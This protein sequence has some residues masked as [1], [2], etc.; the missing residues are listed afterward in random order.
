MTRLICTP[1]SVRLLGSIIVDG[2]CSHY[3]ISFYKTQLQLLQTQTRL[4]L[5]FLSS[6]L[7]S[8]KIA[9]V[10]VCIY[11]FF[12]RKYLDSKVTSNFCMSASSGKIHTKLSVTTAFEAWFHWAPFVF[13]LLFFMDMLNNGKMYK[14]QMESGHSYILLLVWGRKVIWYKGNKDQLLIWKWLVKAFW[15]EDEW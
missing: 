8:T 14:M 9:I 5:L 3:E 2:E 10:N 13:F 12:Y 1:Q 4:I 15:T 6:R 11:W 7:M